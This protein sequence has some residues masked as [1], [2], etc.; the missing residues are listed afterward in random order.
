MSRQPT[1]CISLSHDG[2][3]ES[4]PENVIK[5]RVINID[6]F[7]T[8]RYGNY[9]QIWGF[10]QQV[11]DALMCG[12]SPE[13]TIL[14][15]LY[16][17]Q[18]R[19]NGNGDA[20]NVTPTAEIHSWNHY[21]SEMTKSDFSHPPKRLKYRNGLDIFRFYFYFFIFWFVAKCTRR[22]MVVLL[23]RFAAVTDVIIATPER[24]VVPHGNKWSPPHGFGW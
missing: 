24:P 12:N 6:L 17:T 18:A 11:F 2:S 20:K 16:C 9:N 7:L 23:F 21:C 3:P 1:I 8:P 14:R 22:K 4:M 13:E 15:C 5:R 10:E 19:T